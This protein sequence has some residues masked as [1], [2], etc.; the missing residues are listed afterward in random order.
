MPEGKYTTREQIEEMRQELHR[1]KQKLA[2]MQVPEDGRGKKTGKAKTAVKAAGWVVFLCISLLLVTVIVSIQISKSRGEIPNVLGFQLFVIE[3][4]S[5][6]P[7]LHVGSV[8]LAR[9]P[10]DP[11]G[12]KENTIV[13]FRTLSGA[14][15]THRIVKAEAGGAGNRTYRTKGDN[16]KNSTDLEVLTPDRVIAVFVARIPLT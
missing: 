4:G 12:L 3:S 8:I 7:T 1:E 2:G 14:V 6:E 10:E 16:P 15:V 9:K 11:G 5:M 13:T